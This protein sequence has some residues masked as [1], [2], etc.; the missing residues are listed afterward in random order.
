PKTRSSPSTLP[1]EGEESHGSLETLM[2]QRI[3]LLGL[4]GL[5]LLSPTV[6]ADQPIR[7][8]RKIDRVQPMTGIVLWSDHDRVATDAI[9]LE[10]RYMRYDAVSP[11]PGQWDWASVESTLDQVALR[12]HQAILRFYFV[13]PGQDTTVPAWLKRRDD[14]RPTRGKS[15]GKLTEFCDWSSTALQDFVLDF[16]TA[17]AK[18]YDRDKR[19][20]FLQTGF[21]LW[22]EYHIYDGPRTIGTTFPSKAFQTRFFNHLDQQLTQLPWMV[23]IDAADDSYSPFDQDDDL[24]RLS[25]GL[26]DDSFLCKPHDQENAWNWKFFGGDRWQGSPAGGELSYYTKRDQKLALADNG[27]HGVS[28][29][30]L[31]SRYHVSFMIGN[32]QP[33]YQ[34]MQRIQQAGMHLGYRF[35][36][37]Q[38]QPTKGG[39][40]I[41]VAN[42][43]I[44]PLYRDAYFAIGDRRSNESLKGLLP[45]TRKTVRIAARADEIESLRI[46]C[47]HLVEGQTIQFEAAASLSPLK[48]SKAAR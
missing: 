42:Q 13:Y 28:F 33:R 21:G 41:T 18:R 48:T 25:F 31:A 43:G 38:L 34:K 3:A 23:S 17:F 5:F 6:L 40:D 27:P 8:V 19:L 36:V 12:G 47:D 32:D 20:A 44:A 14:Y 35:H 7:L 37:T 2:T 1:R 15:E 26:F 30:S 4:L 16:Y 46:Q 10:Y 11:A 29:E 9:Q 39:I 22:A 24:Q 45:G